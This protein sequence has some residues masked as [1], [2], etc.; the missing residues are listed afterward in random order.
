[1]KIDPVGAKLL[2]ADWRADGQIDMIELMVAFHSFANTPKNL[3]GL[4]GLW[5]L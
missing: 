4:T 2:H 3:K 5:R 1:M